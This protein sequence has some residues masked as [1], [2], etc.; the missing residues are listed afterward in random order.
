MLQPGHQTT[1]PLQSPRRGLTP[2]GK[3]TEKKDRNNN[4]RAIIIKTDT[5]I[6]L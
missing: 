1:S 4:T 6:K 2:K 5:K 3:T